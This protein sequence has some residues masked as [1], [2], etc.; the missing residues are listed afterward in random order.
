MEISGKC[1]AVLD[2]QSGTSKAGNEWKTQEFVIETDGKFSKKVCFRLFGDRVKDCPNVSDEVVV[3]FIRCR[4]PRM[5]RQ[6]VHS[7]QRMESGG[8]VGRSY[9]GG[10][11]RTSGMAGGLSATGS[12][13]T[14]YDSF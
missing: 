9:Y 2:I 5:E 7:A 3:S 10:T 11:A 8:Q 6:L 13:A 4:K 14:D 12:T 1:V